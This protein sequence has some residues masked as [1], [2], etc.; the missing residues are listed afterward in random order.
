MTPRPAK[1]VVGYGAMESARTTGSPHGELH[2]VGG[3]TTATRFEKQAHYLA[4]VKI[5]AI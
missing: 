2:R 5:A 4:L 1:P 3:H